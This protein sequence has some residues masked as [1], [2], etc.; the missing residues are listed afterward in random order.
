[1][2]RI[3]NNQRFHKG[4]SAHVNDAD[5]IPEVTDQFRSKKVVTES[6]QV[7]IIDSVSEMIR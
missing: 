4:G 1:M 2:D 5:A 7:S 3:G 6:L